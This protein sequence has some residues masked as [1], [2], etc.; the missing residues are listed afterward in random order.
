MLSFF[1]RVHYKLYEKYLFNF[2]LRA[3]GS[4]V[5]AKGHK[6]GYFPSAAF[7]WRMI[8]EN[9]MKGAR[10]FMSDFK[11][12]FSWGISGNSAISPYQTLGGLGSTTYAFG[13]TGAYGFYP[14]NISNKDLGWEKTQTFNFGIDFGFLNDRI[15][16][17]FD[18]YN[19]NT[20]DLIWTY[21]VPLPP[22][23][24]STMT[25]NAGSMKNEGFEV[26]LNFIPVQTRDFQ[27]TS[28]INFSTNKNVLTSLSNDS[29][30]SSGYSDQGTTGEPIQQSTHRIQEGQPI[31]NFYGF[32]AIDIDDTGHWIIED[33]NGQPKPITEAT[34]DDKKIIGNGLPQ[35]YLS[36]NNTFTYKGFDLSITMRGA[37][38]YDILNMPRL[39]YGS[40]V[41]LDRGNVLKEAF[42]PKFGKVPLALDQSLVYVDYYLEKG[43][44]WKIDN[45]TLGYTFNFNKWV[46]RL[47][48]Y[49]MVQ[50]LATITGYSGMDPEVSVT[51]LTPGVDNKNRYPMTRTF[52]LGVSVKF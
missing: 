21:D 42:E 28:Q 5:L 45:V 24:Y 31:G 4:S 34:A 18:Y 9:F 11:L 46:K 20:V 39:Q 50:N 49:G 10:S 36:F 40:P 22:Y 37:F 47:R 52:T 16:G 30:I 3:D 15:T 51:G 32:K 13:D 7:A 1:G 29:F 17:S 8:D 27:W 44:Y 48:I 33:K 35:H 14:R 12:R 25:A 41:M 23:M 2:S 38:D 19:R 26:G 6:W 43:D